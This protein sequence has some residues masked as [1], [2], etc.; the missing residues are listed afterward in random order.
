MGNLFRVVYMGTP[1]FAVPPLT[2]LANTE[3]VV[4]VVTQPDRRAGRGRKAVHSAVKEEARR[5]GIPCYQPQSIRNEETIGMLRD[6]ASDLIVVAAFGQILPPAVLSIPR[7]GCINIHASLLPRYRGASPISAAIAAG[8]S[9]TGVTTM[10]M[11][12]GMDTGDMLM[13]LSLSIEESDTA[14]TLTGRLSLLGA[15]AILKTLLAI[16]AGRLKPNRQDDRAATYAPLLRKEDGQIDWTRRSREIGNHVRAMDPWPGA[17]TTL[18]DKVIKIWRVSPKAG[19]G[20]PGRVL[21]AGRRLVVG[22]GSGVVAIEE[23]QLPG[24][25]RIAAGEFLRGN[26]EVREGMTFGRS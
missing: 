23:L 17:F 8:E 14:G 3:D 11:D 2:A 13:Q 16:K 4:L 9:V 18:G 26:H 6:L 15:Q 24:K 5:R 21:E 20:E 25:K 19:T 7:L 1:R 12:Q 22:A 10:M